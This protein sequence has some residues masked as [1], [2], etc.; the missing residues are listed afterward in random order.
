[1]IPD[2]DNT[3]EGKSFTLANP[4]PYSLDFNPLVVD[5]D[6]IG[7]AMRIRV[8]EIEREVSSDTKL[9]ELFDTLDINNHMGVAIAV[10][11]EITS[12]S[13]WGKRQIK[14]NDQILIIRATNGG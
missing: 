9:L 4:L 1:M 10:N 3:S 11:N 14:E 6:F 7:P 5:V 12:K 2:L 13:E 8:N